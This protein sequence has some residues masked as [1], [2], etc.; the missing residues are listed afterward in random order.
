MNL[1]AA[2]LVAL[3]LAVH[4]AIAVEGAGNTLVTGGALPLVVPAQCT[5][6][7]TVPARGIH[8]S[9]ESHSYSLW[10]PM[11]C[12]GR[13]SYQSYVTTR[14]GQIS[15]FWKDYNFFTPFL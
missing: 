13:Y 7:Y 11:Q 15:I 5:G 8:F 6:T 4:L 14:V 9:Q 2:N 3:V 10:L 12:T 1:T